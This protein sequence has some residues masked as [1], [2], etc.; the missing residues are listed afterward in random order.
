MAR[1]VMVVVALTVAA[2]P[3]QAQFVVHD[4]GN[5]A[6]A[7]LIAERTLREYQL[8]W[9]QYQTIVRMAKG[10][11]HMER[12]R[13][14]TIPSTRHDVARWEYG[15]P[16]LQ[17]L[18]SGDPDGTAYAQTIRRLEPPGYA[19]ERLSTSARRTIEQAYAMVEITDAVAQTGGHQLALVREYSRR[20]QQA[21]QAL[22]GDVTSGDP[23]THELTAVL[24]KVAAGELIARRQDMAANQL[25]SHA[26]EQLLAR[27]K[28]LR[29]TEAAAMNMRLVG[30]RDGRVAGTSLVKDAA[31]DLRTWRQP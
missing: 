2:M 6:Q 14:P 3:A 21:M 1:A 17:G 24:D 26:L 7:V 28:R 12:Y 16:W 30:M 18:N 20:L 22:D 11:D 10:L 19:F 13:M 23:R 31:S 15:G 4:P 8:L 27:S 5:F 25:L 9:E 29:D